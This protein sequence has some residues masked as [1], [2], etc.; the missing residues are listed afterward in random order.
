[1]GFP[2]YIITGDINLDNFNK[3]LT[4]ER[5]FI[6]RGFTHDY[7]M[8]PAAAN[9]DRYGE[10]V[11]KND[12]TEDCHPLAE[13]KRVA[14]QIFE[15]NKMQKF[16]FE[17][18]LL[19]RDVLFSEFCQPEEKFFKKRHITEFPDSSLSQ[20]MALVQHEFSGTSLLDFSLNRYK[21]LY[22]AIGKGETVFKESRI[23]GLNVPYFQTHKDEFP[24]K[25][26][27]T[28]DRK[29]DLLYP[30]YFMNDKIALQEGVF[31]YQ[32]FNAD[33]SNQKYE[34]II[35]YFKSRGEESN[36]RYEKISLDDFLEMTEKEGNKSIFYV[37]LTI[38]AQVKAPLK[39]FLNNIGI[40]E[41]YMM[42]A[43][44]TKESN[45]RRP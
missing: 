3:L 41:N 39:A 28:Y 7:E 5:G 35:E 8:I 44:T 4:H 29:F 34:N 15:L 40:T 11:K 37:L 32:K 18:P 21:A 23:F 31:L 1:M 26:S 14:E 42:N 43:I 13:I 30:S 27:D 2:W 6:W 25:N 24:K 19:I 38:P 12:R 9:Y 33:D 22:F 10:K 17:I 20:A 45:L 16:P 36:K